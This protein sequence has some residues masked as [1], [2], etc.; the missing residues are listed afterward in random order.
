[1]LKN[2]FSNIPL[3]SK[4]RNKPKNVNPNIQLKKAI[5]V[6]LTLSFIAN[7]TS[8]II[9]LKVNKIS[10]FPEFGIR[11]GVAPMSSS[12]VMLH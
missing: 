8:M 6:Q 10:V 7:N 9:V 3:T 1:M 11:I 4:K 2:Y 12:E 5:P